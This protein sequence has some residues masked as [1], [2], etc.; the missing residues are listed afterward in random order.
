MEL[1][2]LL[3]SYQIALLDGHIFLDFSHRMRRFLG[4]DAVSVIGVAAGYLLHH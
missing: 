2:L 4:V 1:C 3:C